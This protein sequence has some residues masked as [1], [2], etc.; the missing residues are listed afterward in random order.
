MRKNR[1]AVLLPFKDHFTK[2]NAGSASIWIKDFNKSSSYKDGIRIFGSTDNIKDIL[3]K[4]RYTNIRFKNYNFK[5][6]NIS[7]VDEFIKLIKGDKFDLVEIHNRPSY[8]HYLVKKN[9]STKLVLIFHN[10]P[11]ALGG[12]K[13]VDDRNKLLEK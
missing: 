3:D 12:S 5:S 9:I 7:Y 4:K 10:N 2:S 8:V 6:K 11:L 1:I 13:T